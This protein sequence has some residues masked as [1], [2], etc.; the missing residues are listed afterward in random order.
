MLKSPKF[1]LTPSTQ[2]RRCSDLHPRIYFCNFALGLRCTRSLTPVSARE[3]IC[4]FIYLTF[5]FHYG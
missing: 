5:I 3:R 1:A 4:S 2:L